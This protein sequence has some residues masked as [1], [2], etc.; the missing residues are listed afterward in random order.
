[1]EREKFVL[2]IEE[3]REME[4][5]YMI[6]CQ[7]PNE[8]IRKVKVETGK[9]RGIFFRPVFPRNGSKISRPKKFPIKGPA[10]FVFPKRLSSHVTRYHV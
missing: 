5:V 10:N 2:L 6:N 9:D 1:V 8:K 4:R 7:S 3:E